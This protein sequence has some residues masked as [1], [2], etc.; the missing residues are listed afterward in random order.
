MNCRSP[1]FDV[2]PLLRARMALL[3]P[4]RNVC[5]SLLRRRSPG[6][7]YQSQNH[8]KGPNLEKPEADC[9]NRKCRPRVPCING[10]SVM[11]WEDTTMTDLSREIHD[12]KQNFGATH[13]CCRRSE[14]AYV[15][16]FC[17]CNIGCHL[18]EL[19]RGMHICTCSVWPKVFKHCPK[20]HR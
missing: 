19:L 3:D 13:S 2:A 14:R 6:S 15:S 8:G 18:A 16:S 1:W 12:S 5:L 9:A 17:D 7:A 20:K 11:I 4:T 10:N